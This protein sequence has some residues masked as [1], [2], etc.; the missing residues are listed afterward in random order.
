MGV[1]FLNI[2]SAFSDGFSDA[3]RE[4]LADLDGHIRIQKY[5]QLSEHPISEDEF[6]FLQ[7]KITN[8]PEIRTSIP[9]IERHAMIRKGAATDG[10][11]VY[12][13]SDS[14]ARTVF[15][16]NRFI[17]AGALDVGPGK[18]I[19]GS[20]LAAAL[21]ARPGDPV[22]LFDLE[23]FIRNGELEARQFTV[24]AVFKTGFAEYDRLLNFVSIRDA[25]E[26][27]DM[28]GYSGIV[29]MTDRPRQTARIDA[30][31]MDAIGGYPFLT[32]T[33]Q[34]RHAT[35]FRW[36]RIYDVPIKIV[37][38][39]IILLAVFNI[40]SS[41]WMIIREKTRDIG[42]LK[43]IGFRQ[44]D[45]ISVFLWEG[46]AIGSIGALSGFVCS[47][48]FL[49]LQSRFK[50]ISLSSNVYF[51]DYLPVGWSAENLIMYPV[52]AMILAMSATV[53]PCLRTKSIQPAEAV[54]YE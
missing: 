43:T 18:V 25:G 4:K 53:I 6:R 21:D 44:K 3:I 50:F 37:I 30:A 16:L 9:Y 20:E 26:L 7:E 47:L 31:L 45:I 38:L 34:E 28:T 2:I 10:I 39:F 32:T 29:T 49:V 27:F 35:L 36:L 41:L 13:I 48:I 15:H 17:A 19:I 46:F 23:R 33:W 11:I 8:V 24:S 54:K 52:L 51:L 12:G 14:T 1:A 40:S 5:S 22:L 42:I